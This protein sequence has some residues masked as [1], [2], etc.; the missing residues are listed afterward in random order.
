[1]PARK[2][3][4][5]TAIQTAIRAHGLAAID[6]RTRAWRDIQATVEGVCTDLGGQDQLSQQQLILI[7]LVART[8][9]LLNHCDAWLLSLDTPLVGKGKQKQLV[10]LVRQRSELAK[11]LETLLV[12]LG[13]DRRQK[14]VARTSRRT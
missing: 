1:M 12:R 13:P 9:Y 14:D 8:L 3:H 2:T 6:R 7:D 11:Q 10:P 5:T 4:D